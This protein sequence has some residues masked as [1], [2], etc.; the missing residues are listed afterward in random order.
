MSFYIYGVVATKRRMEFGQIGVGEKSV[1]TIGAGA[2]AFVVSESDREEYIA[3][4]VSL[5]E[6]ER[7]LETV[8]KQMT[9]LPMRFGTVA[10]VEKEIILM[11][12]RH[13][14]V[15]TRALTKLEGKVEVEIEVMWR[16]M[17][18]VFDEIVETNPKLKRLKVDSGPKRREDV[19]MAGQIV[20][21]LLQEKKKKETE[22]IVRQLKKYALEFRADSSTA[23][24]MIMKGSFL[25]NKVRLPEFDRALD[26]VDAKAGAR[27]RFKYFGPMPPYSFTS[28]RLK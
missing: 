14:H 1:Y 22:G 4:S 7:V 15:F 26:A 2:L 19:I 20:Y 8:M 5:G 17:K 10:S 12:K 16:D 11:L 21:Q 25:I 27:M 18:T 3:N 13:H 28:M 9:I 24:E 23:D 6:H